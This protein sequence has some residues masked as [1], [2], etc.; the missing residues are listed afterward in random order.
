[1]LDKPANSS[2]VNNNNGETSGPAIYNYQDL[3]QQELNNHPGVCNN[4]EQLAM[5]NRIV[6]KVEAKERR[7]LGQKIDQLKENQ[8]EVTFLLS[9]N[10]SRKNDTSRNSDESTMGLIN[11]SDTSDIINQGGYRDQLRK[12][13]DERDDYQSENE[14]LKKVIEELKA[15][16]PK[17]TSSQSSNNSSLFHG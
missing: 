13:Q 2:I 9:Q 10:L 4:Q 15:T 7:R 1:M 12:L 6:R 14:R 8:K 5:I 16:T 11:L 17:T 3:V